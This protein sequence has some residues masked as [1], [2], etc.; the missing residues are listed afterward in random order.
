MT[1]NNQIQK[2]LTAK[3]QAL[4]KLDQACRI[5]EVDTE[6]RELLS[7]INESEEYY[8]SSSCAGRIIVLELPEI[9]DKKN[10]QFLGKWHHPTTLNLVQ[11]CATKSTKGLLWL[12]A[13]SPI[14]HIGAKNLHAADTMVQIAIAAGFKNTG[15]KHL[16]KKI[17]IEI[18]ST[19]RLDAPIGQHGSLLCS[20]EH[21]QLLVTIANH[22]L[23]RS[24][25]KLTVFQ[26]K[27][28]QYLS[29]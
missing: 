7:I 11:D 25:K 12:L 27:L 21:L 9:G 29:S 13:Q 10:A 14:L 8:T 4:A 22:V 26:H 16:E 6:I 23:T 3:K 1:Q 5:Q 28:Q 2:F 20:P 24:Q 15:F 17:T 19:E 18:C